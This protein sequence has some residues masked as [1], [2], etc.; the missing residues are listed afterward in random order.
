MPS[1]PLAL[2]A[3]THPGP[4]LAVTGITV[5]LGWRAGVAGLPLV[6][7]GL[8]MV[9]DQASVGLSN[10]WLDAERDRAVGRADKP[11]A[12][13]FITA[14]AVRTAAIA[15]AAASVALSFTLGVQFVIVHLI[16]LASAWSYNAWLKNSVVSVLP[17]ALSF[18]LLPLIATSALPAFA[19]PWALAAGALLGVAAHFANVLP[20]L[21]D[22]AATGI[23]GL[24]HRLGRRASGVLT[25][26][27]L[28]AASSFVVFGPGASA[29]AGASAGE[30]PSALAWAALAVVALLSII[31]TVLVLT[32]P[33]TRVLFQLIIAAAIID[34][35]LLATAGSSIVV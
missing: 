5:A 17:Y 6:L 15:A 31:G 1:R 26:V 30:P 10:D 21:D 4:T 34:V 9:L 27:V 35:A 22:D 16:A 23:R 8:V 2:V 20:D 29:G 13:G 12:R 3:S 24:P 19:A 7:L 32:R 11:I 33:P 14:S 18:G 25:Y 28:V